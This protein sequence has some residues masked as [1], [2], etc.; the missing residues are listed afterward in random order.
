MYIICI[1]LQCHKTT[2]KNFKMSKT[3][4]TP[5]AQETK[6]EVFF[7]YFYLLSLPTALIIYLIKT[8]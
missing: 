3:N 8:L 7:N 4:N 1:Y 2:T 5:K 6:A